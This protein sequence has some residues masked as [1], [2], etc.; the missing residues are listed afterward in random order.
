MK[1]II[2]KSFGDTDVM[3][4][5]ERVCP[6][7]GDGEV[8]ISHSFMGVNFADISQRQGLSQGSGTQYDTD[9]PYIPGNEASGLVEKIG[10]N[11]SA[12]SPGDRV[13][14]RGIFGAYSEAAV[15]PE[16]SVIK[17]PPE[18]DL[19]TAAAVFT[20]GLTAH[21]VTNDAYSVSE[22]DWI[23]VHAAAG[24]SGG[25]VAQMAKQKGARV[26]STASTEKKLAHI[27]GLGS[28]F[29]IN[30]KRDDFEKAALE[31][32]NFPKFNAILDNVSAVTFEKNLRLLRP[33]GTLVIF[34]AS[35][36]PIQPF[37]LQRLNPLG[38]IAIRRTNLKHYIKTRTE[39]T[40]R[41]ADLFSMLTRGEIRVVIDKVYPLADANLAHQR[42][43]AR[44]NIGKVLLTN[45]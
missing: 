29:S 35:S 30:Y 41:T 26:V 34:G 13:V 21:Y 18:I 33:R 7:P 1:A 14:Y 24:G 28:D 15:V 10:S 3:Q 8:L 6:R 19:E 4:L 43:S 5:E 40:T 12:L 2:V 27:K 36:G 22:G 39:L 11:V 9:L 44:K 32:L 25:L 23:L 37:N 17:V 31:I 42:I 20:Q 38:S 16:S 45:N